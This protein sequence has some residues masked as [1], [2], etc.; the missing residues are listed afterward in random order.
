MSYTT[1][2]AEPIS[3]KII[4]FEVDPLESPALF[5][6]SE[7]GIWEDIYS[8]DKGNVTFNFGAGAFGFGAFG[9]SGVANLGNSAATNV[10][11]NSFYDGANWYTECSSLSV[12]RSTDSGFF[13]EGSS[14]TL[15]V[16]F[17]NHDPWDAFP[18]SKLGVSIGYANKAVY[19]DDI[20]YDARVLGVPFLGRSKDPLFFGKISFDGGTVTLINADGEFDTFQTD[21]D[22]YGAVARILLGF[23]DNTYAEFKTMYEG[24][25]ENLRL[26]EGT[27]DFEINDKRKALSRKIPTGVF[28]TTTY[29]DLDPDNANK[30]IPL[31]YGSLKNVPVICTNENGSSPFTFKLCDTTYHSANTISAVYVEGSTART[32]VTWSGTSLTNATF[33]LTAG[34]YTAGDMVTCDFEGCSS[35]GTLIA[36]GLDIIRDI[37]SNYYNTPHTSTF[38]NLTAWASAQTTAAEVAIFINEPTE[39]WQIIED[40]SYSLNG[41]F[42]VQDD[43]LYTF[44]AYDSTRTVD[45]TIRYFELLGELE[46]AYDTSEVL[47]SCRIGYNKDW[48]EGTY[49]E[50]LYNSTETI[51]QSKFKFYREKTFETLLTA[52]GSAA[53]YGAN[54]MAISDDVRPILKAKT[55]MQS[56]DRELSDMVNV[57]YQLKNRSFVGTMSCEVIGKAVNL[58]DMTVDLTLR[59]T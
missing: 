2:I 3:E 12:L 47:T 36:N 8:V 42:I 18:N 16:H 15:Y 27:I 13:F 32:S 7:P 41:N 28:D 14:Q 52:S 25:V 44:R 51:I 38:Y 6:N 48:T 19:Y 50:Y 22:I 53:T 49:T 37:L 31:A 9:T 54:I 35:G 55:K 33:Q 59:K 11:I 20:F 21:H 39:G 45:Q 23:E 46:V 17:A 58:D 43:G 40:V 30:P 26:G 57:E 1:Y 10:R 4:L 56:V 29:S 5:I 24:Y 34:T